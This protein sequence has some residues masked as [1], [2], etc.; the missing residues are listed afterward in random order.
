MQ[1]R[2]LHLWEGYKKNV[3]QATSPP[4]TRAVN[5][6]NLRARKKIK[7]RTSRPKPWSSLTKADSAPSTVS[8][9]WWQIS[10]GRWTWTWTKYY[11]YGH[12][13]HRAWR[14]QPQKRECTQTLDW[15]KKVRSGYTSVGFHLFG[16]F[17][18]SL[19]QN[20]LTIIHDLG[21]IS[22]LI[23]IINKYA[24]VK[25]RIWSRLENSALIIVGIIWFIP[26]IPPILIIKDHF[27]F[28]PINLL[29]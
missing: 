7:E 3:R 2:L 23:G 14:A 13:E 18:H 4:D 15:A 6:S 17:F 11:R 1:K 19:S 29:T 5:L 9:A 27:Y 10:Q 22:S 25:K 26:V 28:W 24:R 8:V 20:Y 21:K 12:W 16:P